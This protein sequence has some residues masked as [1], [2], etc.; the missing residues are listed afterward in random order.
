MK[1]E[2]ANVKIKRQTNALVD[3]VSIKLPIEPINELGGVDKC[4]V[5]VDSVHNMKL[6]LFKK[7]AIFP[8]DALEHIDE[9][10]KSSYV[11]VLVNYDTLYELHDKIVNANIK[12]SDKAMLIR[13]FFSRMS[14][15]NKGGSFNVP[16]YANSYF[17]AGEFVICS[18]KD[19]VEVWDKDNFEHMKQFLKEK[20]AEKTK[21]STK[22]KTVKRKMTKTIS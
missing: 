9:L 4:A 5:F 22:D 13:Y 2:N 19:K 11:C 3:T 8:H 15:V 14:Y 6:K 12:G 1:I 18:S 20:K 21:D 16:F 17:S 10:E 7:L